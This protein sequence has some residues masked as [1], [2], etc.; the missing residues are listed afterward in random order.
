MIS[1][2][3]PKVYA[4]NLVMGNLY[5]DFEGTVEA[6]NHMTHEKAVVKFECRGWS[7]NSKCSAKLFNKNGEH[8]HDITGSWWDKLVLIEK[9]TGKEEVLFEELP[10]IPNHGR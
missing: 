4:C 10:P 9:A 5:V 3:R 8:T 1:M 7:T 2:G 6:M